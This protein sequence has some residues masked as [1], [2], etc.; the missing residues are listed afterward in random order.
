M[1]DQ[2]R[3]GTT[4][5]AA[6]STAMIWKRLLLGHERDPRLKPTPSEKNWAMA[7][8]LLTL[9]LFIGMPLANL[10]A[11]YILWRWRRERHPFVAV[12]GRE[13]LNFQISVTLY[14]VFFLIAG[15]FAVIGWILLT[16]LAILDIVL[17]GIAADRA[18]S[19]NEYFYP[20]TIRIIR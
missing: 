15:L 9:L 7:C 2:A 3:S 5:N 14:A 8:H 19:G 16:A 10:L 4:E 1:Q 20:F 13:S 11:P 12:H 18:R 17:V 6:L